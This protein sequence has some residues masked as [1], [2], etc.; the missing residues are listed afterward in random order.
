MAALKFN[1]IMIE[2]EFIMII[3][4]YY[5]FVHLA[6]G[7]LKVIATGFMALTATEIILSHFFGQEL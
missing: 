4:N 7:L 2:M 5:T 3:N 6:A 1:I